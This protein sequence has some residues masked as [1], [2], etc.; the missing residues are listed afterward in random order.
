VVE[1]HAGARVVNNETATA[2]SI[3]QSDSNHQK[4]EFEGSVAFST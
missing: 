2:G 3:A 4:A 1:V